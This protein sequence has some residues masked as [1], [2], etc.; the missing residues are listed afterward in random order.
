L[1]AAL[2]AACLAT[3]AAGQD[4]LPD[5]AARIVHG[6]ARDRQQVDDAV[7]AASSRRFSSVRPTDGG[8]PSERTEIRVLSDDYLYIGRTFDSRRTRS[9]ATSRHGSSLGQ[10]TVYNRHHRSVPHRP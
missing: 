9:R 10:T 8:A 5:K 3:G 7:A 1:P 4:A 2:A 6:S